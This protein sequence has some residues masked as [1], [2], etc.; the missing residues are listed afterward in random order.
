MF[1]LGQTV[2][3]K[4]RF[5]CNGAVYDP[6]AF[7]PV[8]VIDPA[9]VLRATLTPVRIGLGEY[10][11]TYT[12]LTRSLM[13]K[14]THRWDYQAEAGMVYHQ[15]DYNFEVWQ[16]VTELT[17]PRLNSVDYGPDDRMITI[18]FTPAVDPN[19]IGYTILYRIEDETVW[20]EA[21]CAA[22]PVTVTG[23]RPGKTYEVC[24]VSRGL[25]GLS[26]LPTKTVSVKVVL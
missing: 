6:H 11:V 7:H 26:S 18:A 12:I 17:A 25:G 14:W 21:A 2:D 15:V 3:L 13:G 9:S 16:T 4:V 10:K 20:T 8:Q 5:G 24:M 19:V 23:L 1:M 22:S